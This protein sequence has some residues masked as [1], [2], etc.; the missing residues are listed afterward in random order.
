M[1]KYDARFKKAQERLIYQIKADTEQYVPARDLTLSNSARARNDNKELVY[2][3][4]YARFQYMGKVM[5][6]DRG[7]TYAKKG[8][9]KHVIS[10]NL[11]Y[12]KDRHPQATSHWYEASES[13]YKNK[14]VQLV[15]D[16]VKYG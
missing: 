1:S 11:V 13:R 4:P 16:V 2:S 5:V 9:K 10:K 6:D 7:S 15:K 3:T 8:S 12:S 14:W